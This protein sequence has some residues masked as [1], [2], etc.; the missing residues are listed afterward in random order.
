MPLF[1]GIGLDAQWD[2]WFSERVR[3]TL[4]ALDDNQRNPQKVAKTLSPRRIT[5]W[6]TPDTLERSYSAKP[7]DF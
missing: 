5:H 4:F 7:K 2:S 1:G 6:A 3:N